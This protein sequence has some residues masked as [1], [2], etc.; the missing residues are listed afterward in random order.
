MRQGGRIPAKPR[1]REI[2]RESIPATPQYTVCICSTGR[3]TPFE[4]RRAAAEPPRAGPTHSLAQYVF[5]QY[6]T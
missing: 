5:D 4:A 3:A 2:E 6:F 1:E